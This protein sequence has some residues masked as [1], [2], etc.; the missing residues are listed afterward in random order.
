MGTLSL[1]FMWHILSGATIGPTHD[2]Y[3]D[4]MFQKV[5]K[6][7]FATGKY[8]NQPVLFQLLE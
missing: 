1:G 3:Y 6:L 7:E 8:F 5:S 4:S 2:S